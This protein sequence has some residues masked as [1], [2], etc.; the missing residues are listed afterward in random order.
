[1]AELV[2][3]LLRVSCLKEVEGVVEV[4]GME[5]HVVSITRWRL[6]SDV[7]SGSAAAAAS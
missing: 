1:M 4:A 2:G 3:V 5:S 7:A 6:L